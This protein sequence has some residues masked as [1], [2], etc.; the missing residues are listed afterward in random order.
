MKPKVIKIYWKDWKKLRRIYPGVRNETCA[1]YYER[2]IKWL[3]QV[4]AEWG[5]YE[6]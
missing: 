5:G 6:T 1:Q 2:L 4:Q 3:E